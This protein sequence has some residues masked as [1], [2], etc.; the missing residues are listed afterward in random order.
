VHLVWSA[1]SPFTSKALDMVSCKNEAI[2]NMVNKITVR[3]LSSSNGDG[4]GTAPVA[5]WRNPI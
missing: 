2:Y 1:C 5:F 3:A 4:P